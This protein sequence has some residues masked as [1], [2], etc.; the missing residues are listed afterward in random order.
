MAPLGPF[1]PNPRLAVAVSGGA[2]SLALAL[3]ANAWA[4]ARGGEVSGLIVDHGLRAGSANEAEEA[5]ARLAGFGVQARVLRA[6]GLGHGP[7]LAARARAA[8]YSLL[9]LACADAAIVHLLLGHHAADQAE[10]VIM[11]ALSGSGPAGLAG[12]AA[13]VEEAGLRVLRPLLTVPP[14]R[15][16]ATLRAASLGWVEDPSNADRAALRARLRA[17]RADRAGTGPATA[18]LSAAACAAG[19]RRACAEAETAD[20][21]AAHMT[22]R[23]E[24][25]A[26]LSASPMP[27]AALHAAIAAIGGAVLPPA[28]AALTALAAAPHPATL[29]GVRLLDAGRLGPGLLAVREAAAMAPPVPAQPGAVWDGRFRLAADALPPTGAMLGALG[30]AA[31]RLRRMSDLP[32]AVLHTMPALWKDGLPVAVPHLGWPDWATCSRSCV[33][34][35]PARPA[36]SA[37]FVPA[38]EV[39]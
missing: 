15:L 37:G 25:F 36:G 22:F 16:R 27:P 5:R 24:G 34:F 19:V 13:L 14:A 3:L 9:R 7:A 35:A 1:E 33:L 39:V 20:F 32:A 4:R 17:L 21:L 29:A 31:A 11:R 30:P 23:P 26:L 18:A 38:G 28:S 8:R 2:D 10:T 12:M 6:M